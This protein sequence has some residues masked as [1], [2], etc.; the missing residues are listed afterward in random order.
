M[1]TKT[2]TTTRVWGIQKSSINC[3]LFMIKRPFIGAIRKG[4]RSPWKI[5]KRHSSMT[6]S[7]V[8][9]YTLYTGKRMR[10]HQMSKCHMFNY[11]A[12]G[13]MT[14]GALPITCQRIIYIA[15]KFRTIQMEDVG[16]D[17]GVD[18]GQTCASQQQIEFFHSH[19]QH[20][21]HTYPL[22]IFIRN[23]E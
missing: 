10:S 15:R 14:I 2:T 9:W 7:R 19:T 4:S 6:V 5:N 16:K 23:S 20:T 3:Y 18:C 17:G 11:V 21:T 8:D 1:T 12:K 13:K 22:Y